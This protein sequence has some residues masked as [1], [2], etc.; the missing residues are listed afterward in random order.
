MITGLG[1]EHIVK[2]LW[3]SSYGI[4]RDDGRRTGM[5]RDSLA[6]GI[7]DSSDIEIACVSF[8]TE[9]AEGRF[10]RDDVRQLHVPNTGDFRTR[11]VPDKKTTKTVCDWV[12]RFEP[13]LIHVWGSESGWGLFTGRRILNAPCVLEMQ[14]LKSA[15]GEVFTG[16]LS[17]RERISCLGLKEVLRLNWIGR[18]AREFKKWKKIEEEIVRNHRYITCQSDWM[19]ARVRAWNR[20]ARLFRMNLALRAPF[21][22]KSECTNGER[23]EVLC[24]A[25]YSA[26][27]K[28]LHIAVRA[29]KIVS[30]QFP[31]LRLGIIGAL[32]H[33]GLRRDG[34]LAWVQK[35]VRSLGIENR[36]DWVGAME[37]TEL[38]IRLRNA[39]VLLICSFCENCSTTMQEG[40]M[41]GVP[42]VASNA[43]GLPSIGEDGKSALFYPPGDWAMCAYQIERLLVDK[44]LRGKI[45]A[46][47]RTIARER[48]RLG[49]IISKQIEIYRIVKNGI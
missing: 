33:T 48:N 41:I 31:R 12:K 46:E 7:L 30:Q 1:E 14:G 28:G 36:V 27:F 34:Y 20:D 17:L 38:A 16:G 43:G 2:V 39:R 24:V 29:F 19:V 49:D 5:W 18:Q 22:L 37:A 11:G 45:V 23:D 9:T 47:A 13:D 32:T 6:A 35:E 10:D 44:V 26:P 15:V 40:M 25:A 21:Y 42:V 8:G 4:S 3:L